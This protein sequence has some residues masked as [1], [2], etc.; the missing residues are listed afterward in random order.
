LEFIRRKF[1]NGVAYFIVNTSREPYDDWTPI[2][3]KA[4][5]IVIFDP[6]TGS[7]G[8]ASLKVDGGTQVRM[9]LEPGESCIVRTY[10]RSAAGP[11]YSYVKPTGDAAPIAGSW[12]VTFIA[13]GPTLPA[14]IEFSA[15]KLWTDVDGEDVKNFSGIGRYA[16]DFVRPAGVAD[17]WLLD[18][19]ELRESADVRL[20]GESLGTVFQAP[21]QVR[22]PAD[23]LKESN[24]LEIDVANLMANRIA[25]LD[26]RDVRW[27]KFFNV[28]VAPRRPENRGQDG[29][30]SA[31]RWEPL[32]SGLAGPVTLTPV[33]LGPSRQ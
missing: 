4:S 33:H 2:S 22:I 3:A 7:S 23:K 11:E 19:G 28:N 14:A 21:F 18:L 16:I 8:L 9:Q 29:A 17:A 25:D 6:I 30:F 31:A 1:D 5:T 20:N 10:D 27:Q 32:P 13:G 15:L 24:A 12:K 26:R